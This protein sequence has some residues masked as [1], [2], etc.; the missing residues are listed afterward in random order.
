M[1]AEEKVSARQ[2]PWNPWYR[3]R[4]AGMGGS[5]VAELGVCVIARATNCDS[6]RISAYLWGGWQ[7]LYMKYRSDRTSCDET[8][9][10]ASL[11]ITGTGGPG[12]D[13]LGNGLNCALPPAPRCIVWC[14]CELQSALRQ[15]RATQPP[16]ART[17]EPTTHH[18]APPSFHRTSYLLP[19]CLRC[20]IH[21]SRAT[22]SGVAV[23]LRQ[24]HCAG[25]EAS[26]GRNRRS[27][28]HGSYR[29]CIQ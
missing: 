29:P 3:S 5:G 26:L 18:R 21:P 13:R 11:P 28:R 16:F 25:L 8:A 4:L 14:V 9:Q 24:T 23:L 10:S 12:A 17:T 2:N 22:R 20:R 15:G 19:P 27:Q 6:S 7:I 1:L